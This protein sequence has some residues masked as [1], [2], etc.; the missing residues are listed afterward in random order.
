MTSSGYFTDPLHKRREF[1]RCIRT[2]WKVI[3]ALLK[4]HVLTMKVSTSE[5][6]SIINGRPTT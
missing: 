3:T 4:E 1:E 2:V 5:V 6:K